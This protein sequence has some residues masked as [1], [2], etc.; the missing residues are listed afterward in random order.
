MWFQ[1]KYLEEALRGSGRSYT[2]GFTL[3]AQNEEMIPRISR[4][5]DSMYANST[6]P[7][8]TESEY[9][10][11]LSFLSFLGNVKVILMTICGAVT[12]TILLISANTIAMSVRER[13]REVGVLKTLGFRSSTILG[14]ILG[15]SA[16]MSLAGGALGLVLAT[17]LCAVVR[18]APAFVQQT[19]TLTIQP[20]IL[21]LLLGVSLAI[22]LASAIVPAWNA[23]RSNIID[24]L[25]FTD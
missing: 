4:D 5:I 9:A 22:G 18:K 17:G 23:S 6:A 12:F 21:A 10:F 7:T 15:E 1:M 24:A 25:R 16:L 13:V 11:G 2:G 20:P 14:L 8:R 19:K 3:L